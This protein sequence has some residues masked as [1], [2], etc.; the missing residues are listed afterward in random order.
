MGGPVDESAAGLSDRPSVVWVDVTAST[1]DDVMALAREGAPAGTAI[2]ARTQTA[3]RGR[4]GRIWETTPGSLALS[5]LL[6]PTVATLRWPV[7]VLSGVAEVANLLGLRIKWPNDLVL[8]DG[9]KVGGVLA[10]ADTRSGALVIGL[11]INVTTAP[12]GAGWLSEVGPVP[13]DLPGCV[14]SA[15]CD[16]VD[17]LSMWRARA[18]GLERP[19]S[20]AGVEGV[21]IGVADDGAL[22]VRTAS[23]AVVRVL[24]GDV[25]M[26]G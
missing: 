19:V 26:I 9:R 14:V 20:V 4:L 12:P 24:A 3:G 11:G 5:V 13:A 15:L 8:V 6:R 22:C 1:N 7:L 17:D 10:E 18:W 25:R 2:V 21:A 16:A 23:G